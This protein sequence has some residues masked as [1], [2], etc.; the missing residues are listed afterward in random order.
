MSTPGN[1]QKNIPQPDDFL[2]E[3]QEDLLNNFLRMDASFRTDHVPFNDANQGKHNHVQ[4]PNESV[5]NVIP[6]AVANEGILFTRTISDVLNLMFRYQGD[7]GNVDVPIASSSVVS[8]GTNYSINLGLIQ[9]R[10]GRFIIPN[11]S[12]ST[13][14]TFASPFSNEFIAGFFTGYGLESNLVF[15][16]LGNPSR[17]GCTAHYSIAPNTRPIPGYEASYLVLGR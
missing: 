16:S 5:T 7:S 2:S 10:F 11:P 3:S 8:Q 6:D 9:L 14:I 13:P 15:S 1:Y 17:T 4:L 12:T